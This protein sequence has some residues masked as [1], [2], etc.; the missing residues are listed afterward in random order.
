MQT[1]LTQPTAELTSALSGLD[2]LEVTPDGEQSHRA[3]LWAATWPKAMAVGA[4]LLL[5]QAVVWAHLKPDYVLPGP[6]TVLKALWH[7]AVD[8]GPSGSHVLLHAAATTMQRAA[9]DVG[10]LATSDHAL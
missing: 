5:W 10:L 4:V 9:V 2:A 6:I 3:R 7:G 1:D 8:S